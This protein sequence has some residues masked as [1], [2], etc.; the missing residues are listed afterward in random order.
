[1]DTSLGKALIMITGVLLAML[2]IGF[3]TQTF[4]QTSQWASAEDQ[5]KK[6]RY[7]ESAYYAQNKPGE[8]GR[9]L[10]TRVYQVGAVA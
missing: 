2:V 3:V 4:N 1:M 5:E 6:D 7:A 9:R 10:R 8:R